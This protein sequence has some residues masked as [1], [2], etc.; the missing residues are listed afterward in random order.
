MDER[1]IRHSQVIVQLRCLN[2]SFNSRFMLAERCIDKT[3]IGENLGRIC[4]S[5]HPK[6]RDND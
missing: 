1:D 6:I 3:H 2:E 5:L 4:N